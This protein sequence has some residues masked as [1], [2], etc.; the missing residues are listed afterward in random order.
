MCHGITWF[1]VLCGHTYLSLSSLILCRESILR[2]HSCLPCVDLIWLPL[3]GL[4]HSCGREKQRERR[5]RRQHIAQ[6]NELH[7]WKWDSRK[8]SAE[9][10]QVQ[11]EEQHDLKEDSPGLRYENWYE[12]EDVIESQ[13]GSQHGLGM[14]DTPSNNESI[15]NWMNHQDYPAQGIPGVMNTE[16]QPVKNR[17]SCIPVPVRGET[18]AKEQPR[19]HR[20]QI[21]VASNRLQKQHHVE[22]QDTSQ[23]SEGETL[24]D[25]MEL[26]DRITF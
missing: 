5:L 19:S 1:H 4:C 15:E 22:P 10:Y 7:A 25:E 21:P 14:L 13:L 12:D 11:S 2:G 16:H 26:F 6:F 3:R 23:V 24:V 18:R 9:N 17:R 8:A 20:S